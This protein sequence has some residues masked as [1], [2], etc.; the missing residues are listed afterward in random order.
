MGS[1]LVLFAAICQIL[2]LV[3]KF[4]RYISRWTLNIFLNSVTIYGVLNMAWGFLDDP[5]NFVVMEDFDI[6]NIL[7]FFFGKTVKVY[8]LL[9]FLTYLQ[10]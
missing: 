1:W 2:F 4:Y 7:V 5:P 6:F 3:A 8:L 9:Q 10:K